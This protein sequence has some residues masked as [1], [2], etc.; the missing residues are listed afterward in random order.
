MNILIKRGNLVGDLENKMARGRIRK[1]VQ[2]RKS[3]QVRKRVQI[4]KKK[5]RKKIPTRQ[6]SKRIRRGY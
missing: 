6:K 1:T 2:K 5:V 4:R 3:V